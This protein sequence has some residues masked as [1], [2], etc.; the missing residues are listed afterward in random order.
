MLP[1]VFSAFAARK[2]V[3]TSCLV[4]GQEKP[5]ESDIQSEYGTLRLFDCHC[6]GYSKKKESNLPLLHSSHSSKVIV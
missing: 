5:S 2:G 4:R 1:V 3:S 6:A